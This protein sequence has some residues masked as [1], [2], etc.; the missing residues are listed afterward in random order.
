MVNLLLFCGIE[1]HI[2]HITR[3][4]DKE[5]R[6]FIYKNWEHYN[7]NLHSNHID[8]RF[9]FVSVSLETILLLCGEETRENEGRISIFFQKVN[10]YYQNHN[11]STDN[12]R[13]VDS[14]NSSDERVANFLLSQSLVLSIL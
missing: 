8:L 7:S 9:I 14:I 2:I 10:H 5:G 1:M 11:G 13:I 4:T 3:T 6:W 12:K